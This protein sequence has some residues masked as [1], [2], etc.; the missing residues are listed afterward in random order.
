LIRLPPGC[1]F[2]PRCPLV[3]ERCEAEEPQLLATDLAHHEVACH[4]WEQVAAAP[5]PTMLFRTE[6]VEA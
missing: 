2:S 4:N 6:G 5:D 1:P 3:T